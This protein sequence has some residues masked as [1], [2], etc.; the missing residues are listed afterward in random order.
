[1]RGCAMRGSSA[2]SVEVFGLEMNTVCGG[3][4]LTRILCPF[5]D[6]HVGVYACIR[7][8]VVCLYLLPSQARILLRLSRRNCARNKASVT[9][10]SSMSGFIYRYLLPYCPNPFLLGAAS[11]V[12]ARAR[13]HCSS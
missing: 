2:S 4:I 7:G 1:M 3:C 8:C 6:V 13:L 5:D 11:F 10:P 12:S 9:V